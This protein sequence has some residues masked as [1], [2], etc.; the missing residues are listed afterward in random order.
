[1]AG[2]GP[3]VGLADAID[4]LREELADAMA[5]GAGHPMRFHI[6]PIELTI[7]A[8]ITKDAGGKIGWG[9]LGI[10]SSY[11][12]AS[13]QTL[14]LTLQPLWETPQGELVE[15]PVIADQTAEQQRFGP[16]SLFRRLVPG[17]HAV[18]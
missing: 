16:Q 6:K 11:Q 4:A 10:G 14:T 9:A 7:Q 17:T 12:S 3:V 1:M 8:V 15:N 5:R 18:G 13:T 2:H